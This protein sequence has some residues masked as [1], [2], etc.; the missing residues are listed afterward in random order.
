MRMRDEVKRR[1]MK[2]LRKEL[3]EEE[4]EKKREEM[5]G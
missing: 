5:K 2:E 1:E 4:D 3:V